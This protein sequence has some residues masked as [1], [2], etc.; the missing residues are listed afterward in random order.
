MNEEYNYCQENTLENTL[1]LTVC[2][3]MNQ[4]ILAAPSK[5]SA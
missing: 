2:D 5:K 3:V 4:L 1:E